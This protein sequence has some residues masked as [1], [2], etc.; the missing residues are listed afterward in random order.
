MIAIK[1]DLTSARHRPRWEL[2]SR[3][4]AQTCHLAITNTV[5]IAITIDWTAIDE[6]FFTPGGGPPRT[7][8]REGS[9]GCRG[10]ASPKLVEDFPAC[11]D[12]AI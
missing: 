1:I 8:G 3:R 11:T 7:N 10:V 2:G 4:R 6:E 5:L 9:G 12:F